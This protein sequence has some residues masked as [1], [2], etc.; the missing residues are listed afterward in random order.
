MRRVA[1]LG[2]WGRSGLFCVAEW[3]GSVIVREAKAITPSAWCWAAKGSTEQ[4]VLRGDSGSRGELPM[5]P[6][7]FGFGEDGWFA[8]SAP[9][10]GRVELATLA[11]SLEANICFC[12][13]MGR[14]TA[15]IHLGSPK[16]IKEIYRDLR[17]RKLG[18]LH[19]AAEGDGGCSAATIGRCGERQIVRE[20][21][22]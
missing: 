7:V 1:G 5:I 22:V 4:I 2:A 12:S 16:A 14:E 8:G 11:K 21:E 10:C 15:N 17:R 18:W 9:D 3:R 19:G 20:G 6:W 13:A